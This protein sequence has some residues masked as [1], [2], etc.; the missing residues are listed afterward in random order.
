MAADGQ[1]DASV[2]APLLGVALSYAS[3]AGQEVLVADDPDQMFVV[4]SDAALAATDVGINAPLTLGTPSTT[5]KRSG[6]ELDGA[7]AAADAALDVKI[8]GISPEPGNEA[9]A[10]N[11]DVIVKINSHFLGNIVAGVA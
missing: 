9:G 1:I 6:C 4:Q 3:A 11:V 8:L 7:N 5:Y 2:T 10:V